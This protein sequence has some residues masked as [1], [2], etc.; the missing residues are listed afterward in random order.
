MANEKETNDIEVKTNTPELQAVAEKVAKVIH[1]YRSEH[2]K[3]L[4]RIEDKMD[5]GL[6][7]VKKHL[8]SEFKT[9]DERM[10]KEIERLDELEKTIKAKNIALASEPK[11]DRE[12][13]EMDRFIKSFRYQG[14]CKM[15]SL[16]QDEDA[17]SRALE[18]RKKE[19]ATFDL[20]DA[21][22]LVM[23]PQFQRSIEKTVQ[24]ISHIENIATVITTKNPEVKF[25]KQTAHT[26]AAMRLETGTAAEETTLL[27]G[28][29]T[30][31]TYEEYVYLKITEWMLNDSWFNMEEYI[32]SEA[33]EAMAKLRGTKFVT[34]SGTGEPE[35]FMTNSSIGST[36]QEHASTI[37]NGDYV[38]GLIYD[39]KS[40][41]TGAGRYAMNRATMKALSILKGGDG[42]YLLSR[43]LLLDGSPTWQINGSPVIECPDMA[44]IGAN[45]YPVIYGDFRTGYVIVNNPS[46]NVIIDP[47]TNITTG[48][49]GY[50]FKFR[51]G[52]GVKQAEAFRSLKIAVT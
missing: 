4:K 9:K 23:P 43:N 11:T 25:P 24:E 10:D 6:D 29:I 21:G 47:Y 48:I 15:A 27:H 1:D 5:G 46:M 34:G 41:Y 20:P 42:H 14:L 22:Y 3:E 7:E 31:Q 2:E 26:T 33:A 51:F 39:V 37:D 13:A 16:T 40:F 35:G 49:V 8:S 50:M 18:F 38:L 44:D 28:M 52:G 17:M 19:M 36:N 32:R 30:I 45:A 12:R